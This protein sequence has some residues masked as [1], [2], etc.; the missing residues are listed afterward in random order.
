[1]TPWQFT[2]FPVGLYEDVARRQ[3]RA[4]FSPPAGQKHQGVWGHPEN[5]RIE[6]WVR[7]TR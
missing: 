2:R 5:D 1:M 6:A 7:N 3:Q 4:S